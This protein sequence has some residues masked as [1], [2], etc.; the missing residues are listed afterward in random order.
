MVS[1]WDFI[2]IPVPARKSRS[3]K[4][5]KNSLRGIKKISQEPG[6]TYILVIKKTGLIG[7]KSCGIFPGHRA[8]LENL[9]DQ[10]DDII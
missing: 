8:F 4:N 2:A 9:G 1:E 6:K 10:D 7:G 5:L 3:F